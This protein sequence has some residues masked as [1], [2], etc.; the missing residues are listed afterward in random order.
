MSLWNPFFIFSIIVDMAERIFIKT[1]YIDVLCK[2]VH[3]RVLACI[4]VGVT[5]FV[6]LFRLDSEIEQKNT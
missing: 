2:E 3:W 4:V 5:N 6:Y 1:V